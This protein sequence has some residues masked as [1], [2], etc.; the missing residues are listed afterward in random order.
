[1]TIDEAIREIAELRG[2]INS[3][4]SSM[5]KA[6]IARLYGEVLG[7]TFKPTTCR[8]CYRDACIEMEL[9]LRKNGAMKEKSRYVLLNGAIIREFGTGRVYS[10]ANLTD[11]VAEDWLRKYPGQIRMFAAYPDDWQE[12]V[13]K[14]KRRAAKRD[15]D[16]SSNGSNS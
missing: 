12:R 9:Y 5:E 6:K 15:S 16:N 2:R 14:P 7:K 10:N 13:S 3:G 1:M 8:D 11:N 4:L